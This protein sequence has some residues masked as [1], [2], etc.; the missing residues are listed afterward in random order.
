MALLCYL[1][2]RPGQV[3]SREALLS[4]VWPGVVVGDDSLTQAVIKL[5]KALGDTAESPAYIQ[6]IPKGGYRLVAPVVRAPGTAIASAE[7]APGAPDRKPR[8]SI[9]A[10]VVVASLAAAIV[11][12]AGLWWILR[13]ARRPG[14]SSRHGRCRSHARGATGDPDQA[15]RGAGRRPAGPAACPGH[16]SGPG[17]GPVE[18]V[19]PLGHRRGA[20]GRPGGRGLARAGLAGPVSRVRFRAAHRGPAAAARPSHRCADRQAALVRAVRARG[21]R[22][23]SRCRTSSS[24]SSCRLFRRR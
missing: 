21:E 8:K 16:D 1:A 6:T 3:V 13:R 2:D 4:A 22:A 9:N 18:G 7:A 10:W 20:A 14:H 19:R 23:C 17:D 24:R 5:R 15:I 11:G 12:G